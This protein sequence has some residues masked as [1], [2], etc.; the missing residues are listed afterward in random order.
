M[1]SERPA[2]R[3]A[4]AHPAGAPWG[5]FPPTRYRGS[6]RKLLPFLDGVF[7]RLSGDRVLDAFGG[8]GA[9]SYL[10]RARG[11]RVSYNDALQAN[12]L[13]AEALLAAPGPGCCPASL[14]RLLRAD[15]QQAYADL[16]AREYAGIYY[17]DEENVLLDRAAQNLARWPAG[18]PRAQAWF[19]LAQACLIKRPYNLFHRANLSLRT[20]SVPRTF[21][22]ARSW[23]RPFAELLPRFAAQAQAARRDGP[24]AEVRCGEL[25]EVEG[26]F[27]LVYLDPPYLPAKGP[28]VDYAGAYHFLEGLLDYAG[29]GERIDRGRRHRPYR[30]PPSPWARRDQAL[31]LWERAARRFEGATLVAS[32]RSDGFP[33]PAQIAAVLGRVK[34]SVQVL[35]AGG[36]RYA[37]STRAGSRELVFVAA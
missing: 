23:E 16:I 19:A 26:A 2:A 11:W 36:R 22:N 9:V 24:P 28:A 33:T 1:A 27:D 15:P 35:D 17:T 20:A 29:W 3:A 21:G 7:G 32:Y 25:L 8:T 13:S 34:G 14:L 6:K 4:D 37:L 30:A 18:V 12:A 5:G 10:L 31:G